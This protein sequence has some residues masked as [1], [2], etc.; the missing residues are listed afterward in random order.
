M[1]GRSK[2][3]DENFVS[4]AAEVI[5][6]KQTGWAV[7]R[8]SDA[9]VSNTTLR[10]KVRVLVKPE[11]EAPFE[12]SFKANVPQLEE[13]RKGQMVM[14]RYD[15]DDH[16]DISLDESPGAHLEA[17]LAMI[18][19]RR[20][21]I[22][23]TQVLGG[24]LVDL[25]RSAV[26]DK[27]GFRAQIQRATEQAQQAAATHAAQAAEQQQF[28]A[29]AAASAAAAQ[30]PIGQIERLAS[31]RDRGVLSD[32]EFEAQKSRILASTTTPD[33]EPRTS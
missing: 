7:T 30:D 29:Q 24:S 5:E 1:F 18:T 13:L 6:A 4:A 11:G 32:D 21:D 17:G 23:T 25:M 15:S 9:I 27:E 2:N 10:W 26:N 22:A 31:L 19:A 3:N 16:S 14:V 28:A 8:G 12:A 20:P 33:L